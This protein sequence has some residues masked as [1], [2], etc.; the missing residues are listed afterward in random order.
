MKKENNGGDKAGIKK[1][2]KQNTSERDTNGGRSNRN[3]GKNRSVEKRGA[4]YP[5]V[6]LTF[7]TVAMLCLGVQLGRVKPL[8]PN[9]GLGS[10]SLKSSSGLGSGLISLTQCENW[11]GLGQ[12]PRTT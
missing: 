9:N 1:E 7:H 10:D 4:R 8:Q 12:G 6:I 2:T 11:L 5:R 3:D